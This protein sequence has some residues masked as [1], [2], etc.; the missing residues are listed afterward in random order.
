MAT[1]EREIVERVT[2]ATPDGT[3]CPE[4]VGWSRQPLHDAALPGP[5][6]RRKRWDY[7]CV[8]SEEGALQITCADLD[9]VGLVEVAYVEL[10]SGR[11][12]RASAVVPLSLGLRLP[13]ALGAA[14]VRFRAPH[15][16]VAIR[17]E[18]RGTRLTARARTLA[19]PIEADVLVHRPPGEES[20][21]VVVPWSDRRYQLTSKHVA[22]PAE[23]SVR[24]LGR[25]RR[26]DPERDGFGCLDFGRGVWPRDVTWN[27]G[28]AAARVEGGRVGLQ[29]GGQWTDGTG[30]TENGVLL[31]GRLEK[32]GAPLVWRYD[33]RDFTR[34]WSVRDE[35]GD[36]ALTFTPIVLR[37][38]RVELGLARSLLHWGLG[39]WR[40]TVRA[41]GR[42]LSIDGA[43]GW[44]EEHVARW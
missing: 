42:T 29:L 40:G 2:L 34:P 44:A 15:L 33:R 37:R 28:A 6:G 32:I 14:D 31:D 13:D 20:L 7:W 24:A 21:N 9:W 41:H 30:A 39:R 36:V 3:L 43:L 35:A 38:S 25:T 1:D 5:R 19:G 23:G 8:Q 16:S 18:A 12:A 10:A 11:V 17:E 27:W 4:A 26:I 22:R